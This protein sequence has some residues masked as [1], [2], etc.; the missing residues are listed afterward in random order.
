MILSRSTVAMTRA[1]GI[2]ATL[3]FNSHT[4]RAYN[5]CSR[6][7]PQGTDLHVVAAPDAEYDTSKWW[8]SR[9]GAKIFLH[10]VGGFIV[11]AWEL[12]HNSVRTTAS[13]RGGG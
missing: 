10:E 4:R 12:R 3:E 7:L 5:I 11:V 8:R 2:I 6:V 13:L 9:N 1:S